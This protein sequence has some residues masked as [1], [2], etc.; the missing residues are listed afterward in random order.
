MN[1]DMR[2]ERRALL[3]T[4]AFAGMAMVAGA[5]TATAQTADDDAPLSRGDI[6]ILRFLAAAEIIESD[7]WV[8]YNELGGVQ[9][10]EQP[11]LGGGG[12]PAYTAA[13]SNLDGD[14]AQYIHDN[15]EDE[16]THWHFLNAYLRSKDAP[17]RSISIRFARCPAAARPALCRSAASPT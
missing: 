10:N 2:A 13:L 14:M 7:L 17:R 1:D 4:S 9:D 16:L 15:T 3:R 8:Q 12:S 6:A 5:S 11:G